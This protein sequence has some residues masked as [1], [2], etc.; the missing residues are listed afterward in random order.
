MNAMDEQIVRR[1]PEDLV[2][3]LAALLS[4]RSSLRCHEPMG[5]HTTLRVGGPADVFVEPGLEEDLAVA[6]RFCSAHG[7]PIVVVGRGSNL[8]V[9]DKGF[10]GAVI[11]LSDPFFSRVELE[12]T[13]IRGGAGARLKALAI[14]ARDNQISGFEFLEGIPGS[15]G[16][17]LR[18]NAGA[19]GSAIFDITESVRLMDR[20]GEISE[21]ESTALGAAY[22]GCPSLKERIV[23]GASFRGKP[24]ERAVIQKRMDEFS[25]KRWAAQP[26]APSAGCAFKNPG[27][28]PAGKLIDSL[29]LKGARVGG[30]VVSSEH[31]NFIVND[32][33]ATAADV[34]RLM[35]LIRERARIQAGIELE[36]EVETI[37]E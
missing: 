3:E 14:A 20:E 34:L 15:L 5:P 22:R 2:R 18:M 8:L 31:A 36:T 10:R 23:L 13:R 30:A 1:P 6:V 33:K 25:R 12:G 37:G 21:C 29:G 11:C 26:A 16:G 17:A 7:V 35:E 32:Q 4:G 9:K 27:Q 28:I 24:G 19:M